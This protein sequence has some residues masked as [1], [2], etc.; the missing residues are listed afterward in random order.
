MPFDVER[1]FVQP[2]ADTLKE[3][4]ERVSVRATCPSVAQLPTAAEM[5]LMP[6]RGPMS[7]ERRAALLREIREA[8]AEKG[9]ACSHCR[10]FGCGTMVA[11]PPLVPLSPESQACVLCG[12]PTTWVRGM[13]IGREPVRVCVFCNETL[14]RRE[15]WWLRAMRWLV[16]E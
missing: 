5:S 13:G 14:N 1:D 8:A 6:Y 10:R 12:V 15:P 4:E 11:T 16:R 2:T 9:L 3:I 7:V